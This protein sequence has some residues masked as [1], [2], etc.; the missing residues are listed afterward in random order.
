MAPTIAAGQ[1]ELGQRGQPVTAGTGGLRALCAEI[2][3]TLLR[4]RG[5]R[6]G[7]HAV[8]PAR[9]AATQ[10]DS[11]AAGLLQEARDSEREARALYRAALAVGGE[12]ELPARLERVLD[13][14]CELIGV[15]QA[16]VSLVDPT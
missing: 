1:T 4:R 10:A 16:L 3:G 11:E 12:L 14:A 15:Q 5:E 9:Q 7:S 6:A 8:L 2:R 13:A